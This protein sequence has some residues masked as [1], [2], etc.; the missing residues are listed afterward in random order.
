P[1]FGPLGSP[2]LGSRPPASRLPNCSQNIR[3]ICSNVCAPLDSQVF[4]SVSASMVAS[5]FIMRSCSS[6]I[7][8]ACSG[9]TSGTPRN[10]RASYCVPS[11]SIVIFMVNPRDCPM[12]WLSER[13][14]STLCVLRQAQDDGL[15]SCRN[16]APHLEHVEGPAT[17]RASNPTYNP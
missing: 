4:I 8:P 12:I 17:G 11:M 2:P 16:D 15:S 10:T 6:F 7:I 3:C 13:L 5:V 1:P 14:G 9:A